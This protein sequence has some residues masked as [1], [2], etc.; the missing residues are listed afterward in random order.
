MVAHY[1]RNFTW[2]RFGK[3]RKKLIFRLLQYWFWPGNVENVDENIAN[4]IDPGA[5]TYREMV[6]V[7]QS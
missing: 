7:T 3:V 2:D 6:T 1:S 4:I 5:K